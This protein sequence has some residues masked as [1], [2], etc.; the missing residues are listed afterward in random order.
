MTGVRPRDGDANGD[1]VV[2]GADLSVLLGNF[3]SML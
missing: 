2:D 3:G 1:G